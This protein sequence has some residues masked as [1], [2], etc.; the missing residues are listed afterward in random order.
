MQLRTLAD[1]NAKRQK[2][3]LA[4]VRS[5]DAELP[6]QS[7]QSHRAWL[8]HQNGFLGLAPV[9]ADTD[10]Q[11]AIPTVHLQVTLQIKLRLHALAVI[12]YSA[13]LMAM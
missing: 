2:S 7:V 10:S 6:P 11:L 5:H 4:D 3:G 9:A 1:R 8:R 13:A 12:A